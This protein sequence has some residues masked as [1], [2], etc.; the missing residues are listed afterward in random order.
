MKK[1]IFK[2]WIFI[3]LLFVCSTTS[4]AC[5]TS[6]NDSFV[7]RDTIYV[8]TTGDYRPLTFYEPS[9]GEY[10]GFAIDLSKEIGERLGVVIK[11]VERTG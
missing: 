1:E 7:N 10:W 8:G 4:F 6:D 5:G 2:S 3:S 11:F 9:T